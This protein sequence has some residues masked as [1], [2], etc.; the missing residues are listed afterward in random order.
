MYFGS[1]NSCIAG[2][3]MELE[4]QEETLK[5]VRETAQVMKNLVQYAKKHGPFRGNNGKPHKDYKQ[6]KF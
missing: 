4:W 5:K 6:T 2:S 3:R 1:A